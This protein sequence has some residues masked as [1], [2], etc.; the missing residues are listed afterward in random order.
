MCISANGGE[1]RGN[2]NASDRLR[3]R[4][5]QCEKSSEWRSR[6]PGDGKGNKDVNSRLSVE[7]TEKA[8]GEKSIADSRARRNRDGHVERG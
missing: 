8:N 5:L 6:S 4:S 7:I 3:K 2:E 1:A